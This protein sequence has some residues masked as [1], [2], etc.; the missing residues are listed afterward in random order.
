MKQ[1]LI[2]VF[3]LLAKVA[4]LASC[5]CYDYYELK[6]IEWA[7]N[8]YEDEAK[9]YYFDKVY[10]HWD[11]LPREKWEYPYNNQVNELN[12]T[13]LPQ[14]SSR[15]PVTY[16]NI[17]IFEQK[18][19]VMTDYH[20]EKAYMRVFGPEAPYIAGSKQDKDA[21]VEKDRKIARKNE[22]KIRDVL[23]DSTAKII[24]IYLKLYED[25]L[26]NHGSL[27]TYR[28]YGLLSHLNNNFEIAHEMLNRLMEEA[29]KTGQLDVLDSQFYHELG[30]VCVEAM[31]YN[32]AIDYLSQAIQKDPNNKA[33]HFDRALAYFET[34][35]FDLAIGD[36]IASDRGQNHPK[37]ESFRPTPVSDEFSKALFASTL[38]GA[39]DG[40]NDFVPSMC[41]TIYGLG[42]TL[43]AMHQ[44]PI[45]LSQKYAAA[46]LE[47]SAA[48]LDYCEAKDW[49]L[50]DD[51]SDQIKILY[52][53][54]EHLSDTEKGE[55]AGYAIGR[56]GV[57]IFAGGTILKGVRAAR[58]LKHA[59]RLCN[60]EA[61]TLSNANKEAMAASAC[62]HAAEREAL[63]KNVK[64][65]WDKQNK[66]VFGKH[67]FLEDRSIFQHSD[68]Q[69]LLAKFAGKGIKDNNV[70]AGSP[71]Y[72]E[73]VDF[74]EHI[75]I[76]KSRDGKI[77]LPTTR[78]TIHYAKDGAHIVPAHPEGKKL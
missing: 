39:V 32:E 27:Q 21:K 17:L 14:N 30:S 71:G 78:G 43:W 74:E 37:N 4:D 55:L 42:E 69:G 46:C 66:H 8:K 62:R 52:E 47:V 3:L 60:L 56:Y 23:D 1:I 77:S 59:N 6:K 68:P 65:Q 18:I 26:K 15:Y 49:K 9:L 22:Q 53:R 76:W 31:A 72:K 33:A 13:L 45:D 25:C 5:S 34:G 73:L 41:S 51:C 19:A 75:G 44:H 36:Y 70:L 35:N 11:N 63:F 57:D 58:N 54:H 40:V 12:S 50:L 16:H 20:I 24:N 64:I 38:Q 28:D 29:E 61:M 7:I 10:C 48:I 2:C 67:N